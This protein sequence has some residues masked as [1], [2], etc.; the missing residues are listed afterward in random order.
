[1]EIL[2]L[3]SAHGISRHDDSV[4]AGKLFVRWANGGAVVQ[5]GFAGVLVAAIR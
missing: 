1:M 5:N 3:I 2:D 4:P